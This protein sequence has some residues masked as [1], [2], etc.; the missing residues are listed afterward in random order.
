ML[1]EP[2]PLN[3]T[4]HTAQL[5]REEALRAARE[6]IAVTEHLVKILERNPNADQWRVL[7]SIVQ[8]MGT[9]ALKRLVDPIRTGRSAAVLVAAATKAA[10]AKR[11]EH[12]DALV[13]RL[14]RMGMSETLQHLEGAAPEGLHPLF[15]SIVNTHFASLR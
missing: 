13:M 10:D 7:E 1:P 2:T 12:T 5:C 3:P 4:R 9:T 15:G 14:D 8:G 6:L 11:Q